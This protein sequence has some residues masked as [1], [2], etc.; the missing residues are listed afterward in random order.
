MNLHARFAEQVGLSSILVCVDFI[1]LGY[2][3]SKISLSLTFH[4]IEQ[5]QLAVKIHL[6]LISGA[7]EELIDS[8]QFDS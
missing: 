8:D 5:L 3:L 1:E 7:D 6:G 4:I 2:G